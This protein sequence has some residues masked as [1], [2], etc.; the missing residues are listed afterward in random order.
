MEV[1]PSEARRSLHKGVLTVS[2][3]EDAEIVVNG[4]PT[5]S[6]GDQRRYVSHGLKPGESYRYVVKAMIE[7][8]GE[9][10]EQTKIA[11]LQGGKM[12][13]LDFDF[14]GNSVVETSL[15]LDV[16]EDAKVYLSGSETRAAGSKRRFSTT[17]IEEGQKWADYAVRVTVERDGRTL[18]KEQQVTLRGGDQAELKFDFNQTEL[19]NAR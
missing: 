2:V 12:T 11:T 15:T 19:A 7:R 1:V 13:A 16:P 14:N 6:T 3:P 18:T 10:L 17:R 8:D 5:T 9:K 4:L